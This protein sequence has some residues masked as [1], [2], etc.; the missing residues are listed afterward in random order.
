[1]SLA[2]TSSPLGAGTTSLCVS[3]VVKAPGRASE[4]DVGTDLMH[5]VS[6]THKHI[7]QATSPPFLTQAAKPFITKTPFSFPWPG[8][9]S[10]GA[11]GK[12][13]LSSPSAG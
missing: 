10:A 12:F 5:V 11:L 8:R 1:M 2:F 7:P 13:A 9:G 3:T 4:E 6:T